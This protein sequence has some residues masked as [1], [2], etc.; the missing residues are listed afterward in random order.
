MTTI[1]DIPLAV[2]PYNVVSQLACTNKAMCSAVA[3]DVEE[4]DPVAQGIDMYRYLRTLTEMMVVTV[5]Y[6]KMT[7]SNLWMMMLAIKEKLSLPS[8]VMYVPCTGA[9]DIHINASG[10]DMVRNMMMSDCMKLH[11][12]STLPWMVRGSHAITECHSSLYSVIQRRIHELC[13]ESLPHS[14][15]GVNNLSLTWETNQTAFFML[16]FTH[17]CVYSTEFFA[18]GINIEHIP[19]VRYYDVQGIYSAAYSVVLLALDV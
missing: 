5:M 3:K 9:M 2:F 19:M 15:A 12:I 17:Q 10:Y 14:M 7:Q 6:Q 4:R 13:L 1:K 8:N 11:F 18:F 16:N